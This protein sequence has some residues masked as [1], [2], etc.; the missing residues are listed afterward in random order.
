[1]EKT[2]QLP[3]SK[4]NASQTSKPQPILWKTIKLEAPLSI[5]EMMSEIRAKG[6]HIA[7]TAHQLLCSPVFTDIIRPKVINLYTVTGA[8]LGFT[9]A[10]SRITI[11]QKALE[12]G[13]TLCEKEVGPLLRD[14]YADQPVGER[15]CI[16]M[17]P[18]SDS[19]FDC[20]FYVR[21]GKE[22]GL[23]LDGVLSDPDQLWA[24]EYR[25][26]FSK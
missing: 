5:D 7:Y 1:M 8:E 20:I 13:L 26:V 15:L 23:F 21:N 9:D 6:F 16:A 10:T 2:N 24:P 22:D 19:E 11:Y 25:W 4:D 12:L 3:E 18:I 14:N 17:E